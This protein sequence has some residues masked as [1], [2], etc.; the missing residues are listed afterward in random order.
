MYIHTF[1]WLIFR[2]ELLGRQIKDE[3][4]D[5]KTA[6]SDKK[7]KNPRNSYIPDSV[8]FSLQHIISLILEMQFLTKNSDK[9]LSLFV[10]TL[11]P[12]NVWWLTFIQPSRI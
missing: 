3:K 1:T 9:M 12:S 11:P 4:T 8:F 2:I 5:W 7:K 10:K 6:M